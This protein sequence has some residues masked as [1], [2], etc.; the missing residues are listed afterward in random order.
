MKSK[1]IHFIIIILTIL[2]YIMSTSLFET[3]DNPQLKTNPYNYQQSFKLT[4]PTTFTD[5]DVV[6]VYDFIYKN[7]MRYVQ[8]ETSYYNSIYFNNWSIIDS[9]PKTQS[10]AQNIN[11]P[12]FKLLKTEY[13]PDFKNNEQIDLKRIV[14]K[15][16]FKSGNVTI[17]Y[18]DKQNLS[19]FKTF[20]KS[21]NVKLVESNNIENTI[22]KDV[23]IISYLLVVVGFILVLY[24]Y[25]K[26]NYRLF[27]TKR[28]VGYSQVRCFID[29]FKYLFLTTSIT[30]GLIIYKYLND[31][32]IIEPLDYL[33]V[34]F[35]ACSILLIFILVVFILPKIYLFKINYQ[36][37]KTKSYDKLFLYSMLT[38]KVLVLISLISSYG[39]IFDMAQRSSD[40][41]SNAN[42]ELSY[43][44]NFYRTSGFSYH[45][46]SLKN[47]EELYEKEL[48]EI[49]KQ[50]VKDGALDVI[51]ISV[52][53]IEEVIKK[54]GLTPRSTPEMFIQP[55]TSEEIDYINFLII[56][57]YYL[58]QNPVK[59]IN[60]QPIKLIENDEHAVV[61]MPSDLAPYIGELYCFIQINE[62]C[63]KPPSKI[64]N[65]QVYGK[66]RYYI[67]PANT[68][69]KTYQTVLLS[70]DQF[71]LTGPFVALYDKQFFDYPRVF[72]NTLIKVPNNVSIY[73]YMDS[74]FK[75]YGI[76]DIFMN[77]EPVLSY[78][79]ND[80][81]TFKNILKL[82]QNAYI[83]LAIIYV[84]FVYLTTL[85]LFNNNVKRIVIEHL[86]GYK[87]KDL[88]KLIGF[89]IIT[90]LLAMLSIFIFNIYSPF[91]F[92]II[93]IASLLS[94]TLTLL[95]IKYSTKKAI[96]KYIKS[97]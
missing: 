40:S 51:N 7:K 9:T 28:L 25:F 6:S 70:Q 37:I 54:H 59:D 92:T 85:L 31:L 84:I 77:F 15:E 32:S 82:Q 23:S 39:L 75:Q 95:L 97:S 20:M 21:I 83:A 24:L 45:G 10:I 8:S 91:I 46:S 80:Y 22:L 11:Q 58:E 57:N 79:S 47:P 67:Y 27:I 12:F 26:T 3:L 13:I 71:Y 86:A 14:S 34:S 78:Y 88:K 89:E 38:I 29:I 60:G 16:T 36:T 2:L 41:I 50:L 48:I 64:E 93:L 19:D 66:Y 72:S 62:N 18:N 87:N 44:E 69:F 74:L 73:E 35:L 68:K 4:K 17:Y 81:Y 63:Q 90:S 5:N 42:G 96:I 43:Y 52:P 76:N 61:L 30:L 56:D 94:I 55:G 33:F 1:Q 53:D 49:R 65:G